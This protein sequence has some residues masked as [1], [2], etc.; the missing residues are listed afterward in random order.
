MNDNDFD[1]D[2]STADGQCETTDLENALS[3]G[4]RPELLAHPYRRGILQYFVD[5]AD[6]TSSVGDVTTH[7][8]DRERNRTGDRPDRDRIEIA[9]SHVHLPKLAEAGIVEYDV[10]SRGI[11]YRRDGC[12]EELLERLRCDRPV[13][14]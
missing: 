5:A 14:E 6:E 10:R 9:L 1:S 13:D 2:E 11:R 3:T 7:L 4:A 12:L 8:V